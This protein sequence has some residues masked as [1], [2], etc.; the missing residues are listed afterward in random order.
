[1]F[2]SAKMKTMFGLLSEHVADFLIHFK[3]RTGDDV[4]V[5]D[6][7]SRFTADAISTIALG[8]EGDCM[9]NDNSEIFKIVKST[10]EVFS[11]FSSLLKFLLY[12]V[13]VKLYLAS[14]I[15]LVNKNVVDFLRHVTIGTMRNRE[16]NKI[17]R[18]DVIQ[19]LLEV[20]KA[21]GE[22]KGYDDDI[23]EEELRNFSAHKEFD[24][25]IGKATSTLDMNDDDLWIAQ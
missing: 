10:K 21:K 5:Y 6:V 7:F 19:L 9:E 1:M 20:R 4:D 12:S 13:S 2:T 22:P 14:G 16:Q 17:S 25:S 23:N 15:Q 24:V 11:S 18:W 3:R 8:F